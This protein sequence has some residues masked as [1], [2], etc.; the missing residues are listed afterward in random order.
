VLEAALM[1]S[2][3]VGRASTGGAIYGETETPTPESADERPLSFYGAAKLSAE[4][5]V[6]THARLYELPH[7]VVRYAN[8]YG[9]RQDPHGEGGVI[10]IFGKRALAGTAPT[11]FGDGEQTR[12]YVYVGDVVAA[13]VA[14]GEYTREHRPQE[15]PVFNVGTG[16]ET[17]VLELWETMQTL[18]GTSV[19]PRFEPLRPGEVVRSALDPTYARTTLKL[20][21]DTGLSHGLTETL[22]WLR[23]EIA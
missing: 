22:D 17:T 8:V 16:V 21:L 2:A 12:D 6:A 10:A 3:Q 13:T 4:K 15:V 1:H 7:A 23:T 9:P 14:A 20:P 18:T 11:V 5:Y 19:E